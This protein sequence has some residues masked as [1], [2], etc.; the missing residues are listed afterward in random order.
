VLIKLGIINF[1]HAHLHNRTDS[2]AIRAEYCVV[3]ILLNTAI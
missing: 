3:D 2:R 1:G